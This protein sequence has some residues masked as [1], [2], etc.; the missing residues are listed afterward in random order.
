LGT[1]KFLILYET[2]FVNIY[3]LIF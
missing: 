3:H 1:V 2:I